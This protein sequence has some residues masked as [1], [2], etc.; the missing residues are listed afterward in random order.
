MK[1]LFNFI[2]KPIGNSY[3]NTKKIGD[4]ELIINTRI[5]EH[6]SVNRTAVVLAVPKHHKTSVKVG[7]EIIVHHNI[8]RKSYDMRGKAQNSR[9]YIND[10]MYHCPID[11][12]FLYKTNS[13]WQAVDDY[14]FIK[15]LV[16][17]NVYSTNAEKYCVG[18][19]KYSSSE[20]K[21][22]DLV[23]FR[24]NIEHEFVVDGELLYKI[25]S[26]L[27]QIKYERKGNEK[28]Y[29]PSWAQSS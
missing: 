3:S 6:K 7:D 26:N 8:F 11:C 2:I 20:H 25:K 29:N 24:N 28:E 13:K 18:I 16:N 12:V 5:E 10:E 1:G 23:G 4:K 27:I 17:D 14:S 15:P 9:F 22:G 21:P 19:I